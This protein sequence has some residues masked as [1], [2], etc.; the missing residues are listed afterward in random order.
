MEE[1]QIDIGILTFPI[2]K[3][4]IVPLSNLISIM[5]SISR[6]LHVV[7]GG[8]GYTPNAY[9]NNVHFYEIK[10]K[11]TARG[12]FGR[13]MNYF[14]TQ[15]AISCRIINLTRKVDLWILSIGG[16]GMLLPILTAKLL[17]KVV[18]IVSAGSGF[19][20]SIAQK[21]K[22]AGMLGILQQIS[23]RLSDRIILYSER[24]IH[25]LNLQ[26][27]SRK[28][29]VAPRHFLD[30][31]KFT[32]LK[33]LNERNAIIGYIGSLNEA[34][35]VVGLLEAI[36]LILK[37][38]NRVNFLIGGAGVLE[39]RIKNDL[40]EKRLDDKVKFTGW[41]PHEKVPD[42]LNELILLV[43]PSETEGL[44]NIILEAMACGTPVLSTPVGAVP[45]VIT[46]GETGFLMENSSP[47]C[48]A[49]NII[50]T[51]NHASLDRIAYNAG[52]LVKA[53][54]SYANA[55][56]RYKKILA[57]LIENK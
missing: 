35:G 14:Q 54:F 7:T 46:D 31:T 13:I 9:G 8:A 39:T 43:L 56:E 49:E 57:E 22:L 42:F 21:D 5:S 20:V 29:S 53:R 15:V 1:K 30:F 51:L 55:L 40:K 6:E 36:P 27:L 18:I 23:Y 52:T 38:N 47:E 50:K 25:E 16:E 2:G 45:D 34:K 26:Q 12:I 41:I 11:E 33:P 24:I 17:R 44:P 19:R 48:I 32:I 3:S 37:E 28:I 4:G 10:H